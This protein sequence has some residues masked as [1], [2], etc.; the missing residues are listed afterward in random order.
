[1]DD[2]AHAVDLARIRPTPR[3]LQHLATTLPLSDA[4]YRRALQLAGLVPAAGRWR[5]LLGRFLLGAGMAFV[6]SGILLFFAYN[7]A[8]L[9]RLA[10]LGLIEAGLVGCV[11]LAWRRSL[12]SLWGRAGLLAAAVLTGV[13]LAVYG[14]AY[15]T[16]ADPYGLFLGWALLILGWAMVG[17]QAGLW[18]L[19]VVLAN[20]SL[21]LY[22]EQVLYPREGLGE[23]LSRILG[24]GVWLVVMLADFRLAQLVFALNAASLVAWEVLSARGVTWARGRWL[25]RVLAAF[26]LFT[27]VSTTLALIFAGT[28]GA[29]HRLDFAAP[30]WFILFGV[31]SIWYYLMRCRDLF[32]LAM[33][34]LAGIVLLTALVARA[35]HGGAEIALLLALLVVGQTAG[36][37]Y[38]LRQVARSWRVSP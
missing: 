5:E 22:W 6:A 7:W 1:M 37:A 18:L 4:A 23:E 9:H 21:I 12:D 20:L 16:G 33:T 2:D 3:L 13:L 32:M 24:P 10:K 38:W 27:I 15:Q 17:R 14:Q 11:W 36:A 26:A 28:H 29:A 25:P 30:V 31:V 34:L 35:S 19:L 8:G